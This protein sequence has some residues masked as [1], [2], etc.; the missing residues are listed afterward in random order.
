MWQYNKSVCHLWE[1]KIVSGKDADAIH[2]TFC[3]THFV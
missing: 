1:K 3:V 2:Y